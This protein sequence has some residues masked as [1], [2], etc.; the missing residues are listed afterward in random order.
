MPGKYVPLTTHLEGRVG[1]GSPLAMTFDAISRLVGG[2]PASAFK[3]REWWA[4]S[5]HSHALAW[6]AAGWRV[7][8]LDMRGQR[9]SFAHTGAPDRSRRPDRRQPTSAM[10]QPTHWPDL[11]EV[12]IGVRFSW[13]AAG[14]VT[15]DA[16][17]K[18]AF[19]ALPRSPG[20]YRLTFTGSSP[21]G[22]GRVYVGESDNL[23]RRLCNNY[24]NPGP[25]QQT[26]LRV[27]ALLRDHVDSGGTVDLAAALDVRVTGPAGVETD[28]DLTKKANRLLAENAALLVLR[29]ANAMDI[30]NLG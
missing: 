26:S 16:V 21:A 28:L 25:S 7:H 2:L 10:P 17:G 23:H 12:L 29:T 3:H 19:P 4:N 27:N 1:E 30:E 14:A 13:R 8:E 22:R 15:V 20:L 9:V 18:P 5:G 24:R 11:D 6:T